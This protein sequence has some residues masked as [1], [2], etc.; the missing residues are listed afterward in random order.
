GVP[1]LFCASQD[2][3]LCRKN[4]QLLNEW[5]ET[6]WTKE[7]SRIFQQQFDLEELFIFDP[8]AD[9]NN[10]IGNRW[11]GKG[12]TCLWAGYS[13]IGKSTLAIQGAIYWALPRSL[14]GISSVCP[15]RSYFVQSEDDKGDV[16]EM[17]QGV[18][19]AIGKTPADLEGR[20][21]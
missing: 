15:L 19:K 17:M 16:A 20:L 18:L 9:P 6:E 3:R 10:L 13:G 14:F 2:S 12:S 11:L 1:Y 5:F 4:N 21:V 8:T 7:A